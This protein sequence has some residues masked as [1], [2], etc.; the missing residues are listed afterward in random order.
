[1]KNCY[2][3]IF[4]GEPRPAIADLSTPGAFG[5][6]PGYVVNRINVPV[7]HRGRGHGRELLREICRDADS[8]GATLYLCINPTGPLDHDQLDAWYRRYGFEDDPSE[9]GEGWLVRKPKGESDVA[10]GRSGSEERRT[11]VAQAPS[12]AHQV[13]QARGVPQPAEQHLA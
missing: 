13:P 8:E 10:Q 1:M 6:I 12:A 11:S 3:K 5:D 9:G 7:S 4:D 2:M